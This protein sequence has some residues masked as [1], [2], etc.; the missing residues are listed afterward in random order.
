[1][2]KKTWM[3]RVMISKVFLKCSVL[4]GMLVL[5][6]GCATTCFPSAGAQDTV[7]VHLPVNSA[8]KRR[9]L[10]FSPHS[11][12]ST[13]I[14][15]QMSSLAEQP[16]ARAL[17]GG[18]AMATSPTQGAH[19]PPPSALPCSISW[20]S[21]WLLWP[22]GSCTSCWP[23][24]PQQAQVPAASR[25]VL[26]GTALSREKAEISPCLPL[27]N[28]RASN[29]LMPGNSLWSTRGGRIPKTACSMAKPLHTL[30]RTAAT[31]E[32]PSCLL[33]EEILFANSIYSLGEKM[34]GRL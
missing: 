33:G 26:A 8:G 9:H 29:Y 16:P 19:V 21:S 20:S 3:N 4:W 5:F 22:P 2:G 10:P 1:M 11:W 18:Q 14:Y 6:V 23:D 13:S 31:K 15:L 32:A 30:Q 7:K 17:P 25:A 28:C 27:Y 24:L 12:M 34:A